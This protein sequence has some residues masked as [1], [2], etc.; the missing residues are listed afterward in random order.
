MGF[1]GLPEARWTVPGL[2]TVRRPLSQ[3]AATAVDLLVRTAACERAES[4][5]AEPAARNRPRAWSCGR[6]R[7]RRVSGGRRRRCTRT[8]RPRR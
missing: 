1:G 3:M 6:A 5:R 4:A 2:T 7:P 8:R